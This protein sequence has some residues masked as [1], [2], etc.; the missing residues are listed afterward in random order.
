M[1]PPAGNPVVYLD[2][3][4][5]SRDPDDTAALRT[6][7]NPSNPD[8]YGTKRRPAYMR[9]N[10]DILE[11]SIGWNVD[12]A[13]RWINFPY[14]PRVVGRT[15][16]TGAWE[17]P[18]PVQGTVVYPSNNTNG[19]PYWWPPLSVVYDYNQ[20]WFV[21]PAHPSVPIWGAG[22][23]VTYIWSCTFIS[24]GRNAEDSP[25]LPPSPVFQPIMARRRISAPSM[26]RGGEALELSESPEGDRGTAEVFC[27]DASRT[28][29]GFGWAFR[30][31]TGPIIN[32]IDKYGVPV[33]GY[34]SWERIYI[35]PRNTPSTSVQFWKVNTSTANSGV[36]LNLNASR[37]I[38]VYTID[39][40]GTP[41]LRATSV[42]VLAVNIWKR[43]DV[44]MVLTLGPG[45]LPEPVT[46]SIKLYL[47]GALIVD[48]SG[49]IHN[50]LS[51]VPTH[52]QT[53]LGP[54]AGNDME[55]DIC[56][57]HNAEHP[58]DVDNI[59]NLTRKDWIYGSHCQLIRPTAYGSGHSVNWVGDFRILMQNPVIR[60][61][62]EVTSS[63]SDARMELDTELDGDQLNGTLNVIRQFG[64]L[65][66]LVGIAS[67]NTGGAAT[68]RIGYKIG[69][70]ADVTIV[71][72]E[73]NEYQGYS[74]LANSAAGAIDP[75]NIEPLKIIR[76]KSTDANLTEM[77]EMQVVAQF[78]GS[79]GPEDEI[80]SID[81]PGL[82]DAL[83]IHNGPYLASF[84]GRAAPPPLNTV[85]V[86]AGVYTGNGTGQDI[87]VELPGFHWLWIRNTTTGNQ[88]WWWTSLLGSHVELSTF[89]IQP[90]NMVQAKILDDG[91][92]VFRLA[93]TNAGSNTIGVIYQ[94]VAFSDVMSR[95]LL[96][97]AFK[98]ATAVASAVNTL[99]NSTFTPEGAYFFLENDENALSGD[100][101]FWKGPGNAA[102]GG[103]EL[104]QTENANV[105]TFAAGNITSRVA[106]HDEVQGNLGFAA[107]R[108][109]DGSGAGAV[110]IGQY[111]GN[112]AGA[113][114]ISVNLRARRPMWAMIQSVSGTAFFR[115][116]SHL[117]NN[118]T[119]PS[120]A[121]STTG[122]TGGGI[123]QIIIGVS[124]NT[125]LEVYNVFI[126]PA[127]SN[128]AG[129]G[130]W[131][132][133]GVCGL[134]EI[135]WDCTDPLYPCP[136]P[137]ILPPPP[138]P[139]DVT[140]L[141]EGGLVLSGS[142]ALLII[143][144][145][146]GIYTLVPGKTDDT[147]YDRQ[148]GQTSVDLPIPDPT[149]KTGYI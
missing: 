92:T 9:D 103:N 118:S 24:A 117:T 17:P 145:M 29:D 65:C 144:D 113:R 70:A 12:A 137:F 88:A 78:M 129:N 32:N 82:T 55:L 21:V 22:R 106:L 91:T 134:A 95:F 47:G 67:D 98:H 86:K 49:E 114:T 105:A 69:A 119:S 18:I 87:V 5:Y 99:F 14:P 39:Q 54:Q 25:D 45:A 101:L 30:A 128:D 37:Q 43:L 6:L 83:G 81:A 71:F 20:D 104:G 141:G 34:K 139:S 8:G 64:A 48:T 31:N 26:L 74:T 135:G 107:W 56:D 27:R 142:P 85:G 38:E 76:L 132:V 60:A 84:F 136:P 35:R 36:R 93:G 122:I 89:E 33:N 126:I 66:F 96:N 143:K 68:G 116:P 58:S 138:I 127:C 77:R 53:R 100:G 2:Y 115:D 79:W 52:T 42:V 148:T 97:G 149:V 94:Y 44:L 80:G 61:T 4:F 23:D 112:G 130:G 51:V 57:W 110:F 1:E 59:P 13:D 16:G 11:T 109:N 108:S 28:P 62:E 3:H 124:L 46:A 133:N 7:F 50:S 121:N 120:G 19:D 90:A 147:V 123:D 111:T 40:V 63:T 140:I 125:N 15:I 10:F 102:N 41:T 146:S 72:T 131:G 73:D 75:I